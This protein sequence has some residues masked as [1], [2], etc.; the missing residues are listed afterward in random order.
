MMGV[1]DEGTPIVLAGEDSEI[2]HL[3]IKYWTG[4]KGIPIGTIVDKLKT[5]SSTDDDFC[6]M[7]SLFVIGTILYPNPA[8]YINPNRWSFNFL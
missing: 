7:F 1:G 8:T 4:K 2:T 5:N 3:W 6:I